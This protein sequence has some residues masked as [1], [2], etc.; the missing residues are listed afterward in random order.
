MNIQSVKIPLNADYFD[1]T[2]YVYDKNGNQIRLNQSRQDKTGKFE[3]GLHLSTENSGYGYEIFNYNGFNQLISYQ[4]EQD[5]K[6]SY[7]Y[8]P[9]GLRL[10]KTVNGTKTNFIWDGNDLVL[11]VNGNNLRSYAKA[12][13]YMRTG[14]NTEDTDKLYVFNGHG[15]VT[16]LTDMSGNKVTD[17]DYDAFGNQKR[18]VNDFNPFRYCGEYQDTETGLIYLR[19]RYYNPEIGRFINEDPV[20]DG[21][22]WYSYCGGNPI[23]FIDSFGLEKIVVSGGAYAE[24]GKGFKYNFI[25]PS[26][27]NLRELIANNTTGEQ[28][29]WLIAHA[30]YEDIDY[31]RFEKIAYEDL[32]ISL[33]YF[34]NV[35]NLIKYING[36]DERNDPITK[37][38]VYSH[39]LEE[40]ISFGYNCGEA[41][42]DL[43]FKKEDVE[44]L[45][46]KAFKNADARFESC[47]TGTGGDNSIA[48]LWQQRVGG[49]VWAY[50]G[51]SDYS[52]IMYPENYSK[53]DAFMI[54]DSLSDKIKISINI[55]RKQW[56]FSRHGS[57]YYPKADNGARR[58]MYG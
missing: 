25:E 28:I 53:V 20:K 57:D 43:E 24:E 51:R 6:A 31:E 7:T 36:A 12:P 11:E 21:V 5:T 35:D 13:G 49:K 14:T 33:K 46:P 34:S 37:F 19:N 4:N 41:K 58:I 16:T 22:N 1:V 56:G 48:A 52:H 17:Y 27:K 39:G 54:R 30:G 8:M 29:T 42:K 10:S 50:E 23:A 40:K 3:I 38:I 32:G 15:D 44:K 2:D 55:R 18:T 9:N 45:N 47:N 26:I